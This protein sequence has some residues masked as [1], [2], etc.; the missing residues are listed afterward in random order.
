M[1]TFDESHSIPNVDPAAGKLGKG[2]V[3]MR[4]RH[5]AEGKP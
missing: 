5:V 1:R 3:F 2:Y 4:R